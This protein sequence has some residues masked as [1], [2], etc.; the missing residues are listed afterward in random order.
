M[1][2]VF[3]LGCIESHADG[4]TKV[5]K[6][7]MTTNPGLNDEHQDIKD[8]LSTSIKE[9][10]QNSAPMEQVR[11]MNSLID[12]YLRRE[13]DNDF[14]E[15]YE[16]YFRKDITIEELKELDALIKNKETKNAVKKYAEINDLVEADIEQY[17]MYMKGCLL[18]GKEC[19]LPKKQ[20]HADSTLQNKLNKCIE[21]IQS[22]IKLTI[23]AIKPQL[24][25]AIMENEKL[26][27]LTQE[28]KDKLKEIVDKAITSMW[29]ASI[30]YY[31]NHLIEKLTAEE[32]DAMLTVLTHPTWD[33]VVASKT[34][35]LQ[36]I[37]PIMETL[38][39]KMQKWMMQEA[40]EQV[41][42]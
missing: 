26:G 40:M 11:L 42:M 13:F 29:D 28:E 10:L 21:E 1:F 20:V 33:K 17:S 34:E 16:K 31:S 15:A 41:Q 25:T 23:D 4:Y 38:A 18:S 35:M 39:K 37:Q 30:I 3:A 5:L 27:T 36:N 7:F 22:G 19:S 12:K 8:K 24:E 14:V 32:L 6:K 9:G 2:S